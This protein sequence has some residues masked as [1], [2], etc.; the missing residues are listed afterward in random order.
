ME[1]FD[2][3]VNT[4]INKKN[5]QRLSN[6]AT[7]SW[8]VL[9]KKDIATFGKFLVESFWAQVEM[10]PNMV[11]DEIREQLKN[12]MNTALG[13]KVSGAGGRGYLILLSEEKIEKAIQIK[14][15]RS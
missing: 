11:N 10:F 9:I 4:S 1:A 6:A 12:Y 3:L 8:E 14:I 2:V 15:R 7:S 13:Y 5:V